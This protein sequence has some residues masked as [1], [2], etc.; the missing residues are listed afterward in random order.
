MKRVSLENLALGFLVGAYVIWAG[1]FIYQSSY[2]GIDG[3]RY[4]GLFDD[5]MISMRYAW[6]FAHG[7]GLVWN[8]GQRVEGYSNLLMTLLMSLAALV[9]NK[10]L[11]VLSIQ[12]LGI[13]IVLLTALLTRRI[14]IE[15]RMGEPHT[16]L[17]GVLAAACVLLYYPLSYWTLMGMETGLLTLF[18]LAGA[19]FGIRW[20]NTGRTSDLV[21]VAL[22]SGLAFLTR[23]DAI[24]LAAPTF[25]YLLA[26]ILIN[27]RELPRLRPLIFAGLAVGIFPAAQTIF[28][29]IYYGQLLPNTYF[30]KLTGI[31]LSI[32]LV[33]GSRF[34]FEFLQ[35]SWPLFVVAALGLI[36]QARLTRL[37]L[38]SFMLIAIAYQIYAGG[39][40]WESWR[41]LAPAMPALFLLAIEGS[42]ILITRLKG[43]ASRRYALATAVGLLA[44]APL[45]LADQPFLAD[46]S[47]QGPTSAA[48]ANRI[49]TN[50]AIAIDAL[51][52]PGASI[53]VIWAGTL[54]YY[55]DR[56]GVDFLG[57]S[58]A[59]I[60]HLQADVTGSVSWGGMISVPGH[61]KYDLEYSI[62]QLQP[63]YV[64]A[65]S[66]GYQTVKPW[67]EQHYVR[68][69]YQG[70]MGSKTVWLLKDSPLVCWD[71]CSGRYKVV[72]WPAG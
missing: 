56:T 25:A 41:L 13:P 63:T 61:N 17:V 18:I 36:L 55:A 26:E 3:Q 20:I 11:A 71:A 24:L 47:V 19:W 4:F 5:A 21:A 69:D 58:D 54:P 1:L 37:Y 16:G 31:P 62:V 66:W 8:A 28:R 67:V 57:K 64:Q 72:P 14:A 49:N 46:M 40:P 42:V 35:Q 33:G 2:I 22:S 12:I 29:M 65:Y 51:T 60:A 10:S 23:N 59:R 39:D 7:L 38:A 45:A 70:V 30:L 34:V 27:R 52:T 44:L 6:N 48:I 15:L 9:L 53:G 50:A 68:L 32:R 43:L